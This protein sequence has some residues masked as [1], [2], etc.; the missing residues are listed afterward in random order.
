MP[1]LLLVFKTA[2]PSTRHRLRLASCSAYGCSTPLASCKGGRLR[3]SQTNEAPKPEG[4]PRT[5]DYIPFFVN[6]DRTPNP[7]HDSPQKPN[8]I[9][10]SSRAL[11]SPP[12]GPVTLVWLPT[13]VPSVGVRNPEGGLANVGRLWLS[14]RSHHDRLVS[15]FGRVA[16]AGRL[17]TP[18]TYAITVYGPSQAGGVR[19]PLVDVRLT[20]NLC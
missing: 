9:K 8:E 1:R 12:F 5:G 7:E 20:H 3:N 18:S 11:V 2:S 16:I 17:G 14:L 4:R 19:L 6:V 15:A 13:D 10:Q